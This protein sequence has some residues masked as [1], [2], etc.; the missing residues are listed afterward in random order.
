VILNPDGKYIIRNFSLTGGSI[1]LFEGK[2]IGRTKNL[3]KLSKEIKKLLAL[4]ETAEIEIEEGSNTVIDLK[5]RSQKNLIEELQTQINRLNNEFISIKTKQEQYELFLKGN[6]EKKQGIEN[7]IL[8]FEKEQAELNP[9]LL[10]AQNKLSAFESEFIEEQASFNLLSEELMEKSS[11]YNETNIR[12][13]QQKNKVLG[14]EKDIE[15]R[16]IQIES[17]EKQLEQKEKELQSTQSSI[18]AT[19][20]HV[21]LSDEDLIA[22]YIQ[23]EGLEKGLQELEQDY[24]SSRAAINKLE[25][26]IQ[27]LRKNKE[28]SDTIVNE[29]KDQR[30]NCYLELNAFKE[31]LSIEFSFDIDELPDP[32][33]ID[34]NEQDLSEKV[35]RIKKQ[36]DDF[37]AI[38]PMAMEAYQ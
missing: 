25:E 38:N 19:L 37:G 15:Y 14:L 13:H 23:K 35:V 31:R 36:L 1:G 30:N 9:Q 7:K 17:I 20:E 32:E 33:E 21:D 5:N 2:R 27:T 10:I 18:K 16:E 22:L 26:D 28:I 24:Y 4:Q 11:I 3:E 34:E 12:F 8:A 29:L 6:L